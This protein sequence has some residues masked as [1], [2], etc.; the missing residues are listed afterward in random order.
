MRCSA[1]ASSWVICVALSLTVLVSADAVSK[2]L[3]PW[4]IR[5]IDSLVESIHSAGR[6]PGLTVL[7]NRKGH[8]VYARTIGFADVENRVPAEMDSVFAIGSITKSFTALAVLQLVDG[9]KLA[10]GDT[11]DSVLEDYSGPGSV[12]TVAQ[13]LTHT[14][15]IPNYLHEIPAVRGTF[16]RRR[17]TREQ[18]RS[19]FEKE[20]LLFEPGTHWS[21]SNS[22]YYLLGLIVEQVSSKSY[23]EYLEENVYEPLG[24]HRTYSGDD[25]EIVA[26]RAHGYELRGDDLVNAPPWHYLVPFSAGSLLSTAADV[27]RYRRAVFQSDKISRR[28]RGLVTRTTSLQDGTE[29]QYALGGLVSSSFHGHRKYSHSGE[30]YGYFANHAHYPAPDLTVVVLSNRKGATPSPVALERKISRVVLDIPQPDIDNIALEKRELERYAGDYEVG[31]VM[32]GPPQYGFVAREGRLFLKFGGTDS[33]AAEVPLLAQ[34]GGLFVMSSN[35]EWTFEFDPTG[36][37]ASSFEMAV[38]DA[39]LSGRRA[40]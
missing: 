35:D 32:F 23:F 39:T 3:E 1:G 19:Y 33:D 15:G 31:P 13:L 18:M 12:V 2:D 7:V 30:I 8:D 40:D 10:L 4:Q 20:P 5:A 9:G 29:L 16:E 28:L 36:E 14:S 21:Y 24:L 27:A 17:S 37:R 34:G 25:S 38:R 22:G 11:V 26:N 6:Y